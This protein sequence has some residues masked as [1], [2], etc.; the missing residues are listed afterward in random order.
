MATIRIP[1]M[2]A[3]TVPDATGETFMQPIDVA[4][5]LSTAPFLGS[6][7]VMTMVDPSADTGFYG[8]FLV[9]KNYTDTANI[10]VVG[11]LDGTVSTTSLDFE[12]S[13]ISVADNETADAGW[14]ESA[15][16]NTG[17]TNGWTTEDMLKLSISVTDGNFA[18]DDTVMYYFKRDQG[19]D[20][21]VGDFHVTGLYFEYNDV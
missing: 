11:V 13:Y 5:A 19:T 12:F 6:N 21:F 17:N 1:I 14:T 20:D 7:L 9:P 18:V 15:T 4:V 3:G 16:G 2:G 8:S 10:I